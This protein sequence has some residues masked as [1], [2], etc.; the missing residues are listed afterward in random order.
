MSG[1]GPIEGG[2]PELFREMQLATREVNVGSN[3]HHANWFKCIRTR[4]FPSCHEE[5]GHRSATL[6][7]LTTLAYKLGRSLEWDPAK[8]EFIGDEPANRLRGRAM[9]CGSQ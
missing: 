3:D 4:Q 5:I 9:R 2:P 1:S 6:G 7:H 8:E